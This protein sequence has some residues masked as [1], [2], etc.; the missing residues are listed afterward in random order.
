MYL[1]FCL[2]MTPLFYTLIKDI[3]SKTNTINEELKEV[4]NWFNT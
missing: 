3:S 2:L 1:I 4:S